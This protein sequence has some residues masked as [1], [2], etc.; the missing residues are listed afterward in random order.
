MLPNNLDKGNFSLSNKIDQSKFQQW[1]DT[2]E[3]RFD[4]EKNVTK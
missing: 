1:T 4:V 3:G 2:K